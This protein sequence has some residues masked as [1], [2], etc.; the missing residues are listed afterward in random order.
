M[1]QSRVE[2]SLLKKYDDEVEHVGFI[3]PHGKLVEVEN[4]SANP[5]ESFDVS[6]EDIIKY[7]QTAVAS[8]HTHP[9]DNSNLSVGDMETFLNWP[10]WDHYIVGNDGITKYIVRDG[11]VLIG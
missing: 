1:T 7:E 2:K 3:L 8:W 11:E 10:E 6:G 5:A 9:G 4:T